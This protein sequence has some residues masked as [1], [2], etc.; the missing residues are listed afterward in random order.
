MYVEVSASKLT[1]PRFCICCDSEPDTQRAFVATRTTGKRVIK[2]Q[3][4]HWDFPICRTCSAHDL[5]WVSAANGAWVFG[6]STLALSCYGLNNVSDGPGVTAV[7]AAV[8]LVVFALWRFSKRRKEAKALQGPNCSQNC[9]DDFKYLGWSGTVQS[10][11]IP[12]TS[13]A[14]SFM[15][16][17]RSKL[18]NLTIE[19]ERMLD[20]K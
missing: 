8:A 14:L 4:K 18:V 3:S 6:A 19:S 7:I 10:F 12:S 11:D 2:T 5:A 20:S 13:Y 16:A 15:R 17:N 1:I 9:F